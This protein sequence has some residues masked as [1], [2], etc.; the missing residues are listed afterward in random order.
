MRSAVVALLAFSASATGCK[1]AEET[2]ELVQPREWWRIHPRPGYAS[3]EKVGTFQDWFDVYRSTDGTFAIYEPNQFEEVIS[4]LV[5]GS[6]RGV[7]D[8]PVG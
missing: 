8:N 4:Y 7:L 2:P 5:L 6:D 3:L 1:R